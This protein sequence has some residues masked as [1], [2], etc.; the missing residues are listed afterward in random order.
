PAK[1][2][3]AIST[4]SAEA[5]ARRRNVLVASPAIALATG[6][7]T[8]RAGGEDIRL[9]SSSATANEDGETFGASRATTPTRYPERTASAGVTGS[10]RHKSEA[11]SSNANGSG[12]IPM[13]VCD[14]P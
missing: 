14:W 4:A 12:R 13:I 9:T 3:N 11:L 8:T 2:V 1:F 6:V 5:P 7:A 10:G